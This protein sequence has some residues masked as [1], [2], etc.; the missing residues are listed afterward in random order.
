[1]NTNE[2]IQER[3]FKEIDLSDH[4]FDSLKEDYC[5]FENWFRRKAEEKA[6]VLYGDK[7]LQAFLYLKDESDLTPED[8]NPTL[9]PKKWLKVGTFKIDAHKTRLGERFI[10]KITDYAIYGEYDGI[11]LTIF[12][13]QKSLIGLLNRYGFEKQGQK[14]EEDVLV[15]ELGVLKDDILKDYPLLRVKDKRKF[16]LSIYPKY[17]TRLFP[18]SILKTEKNVRQELIKDVSYTNSIHKIYLCFIPETVYL[19]PG[20][21]LAIYR[22]NDGLGP[23]KYRSVVTSICQVEE[24]KTRDS[25]TDVKDFIDYTN[26]YSIFDPNELN[27]WYY[28]PNIVVIRMTYN[29]ALNRRVT[30]GFL[31]DEIGI[32]PSLYWGFFQ[33]TDEQFDSILT[34]GEV[35][36][37]IIVN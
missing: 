25:F 26:S 36:E 2:I 12:P 11:Y 17:H 28:K 5:G 27:Q 10:K 8:I 15:K 18:D 4:F 32:S 21:L 31:I 35:D 20:D 16:I 14:G 29:I 6:F 37:N 23:A 34:K 13:K 19:R 33:L 24:I 3:S 1:M 7:G 30:R 9:P 22:T